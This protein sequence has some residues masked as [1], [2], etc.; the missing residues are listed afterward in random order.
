MVSP[1]K[2]RMD[3]EANL[4]Q[5]TRNRRDSAN[6]GTTPAKTSKPQNAPAPKNA[7]AAARGM[8]VSTP[9]RTADW[10]DS[11]VPS[12]EARK[13]RTTI[14]I[15]IIATNKPNGGPGETCQAFAARSNRGAVATTTPPNAVTIVPVNK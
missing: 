2:E 7:I 14:G 1:L 9:L 8:I 6:D 15:T 13:P 3:A 4:D 5:V 10:I 11:G 12:R